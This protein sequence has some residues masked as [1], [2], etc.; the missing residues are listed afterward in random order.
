MDGKLKN[1]WVDTKIDWCNIAG[2]FGGFG[3]VWNLLSETTKQP[4]MEKSTEIEWKWIIHLKKQFYTGSDVLCW[5]ENNDF[6]DSSRWCLR[7][8]RKKKPTTWL[9]KSTQAE[10]IKSKST[11]GILVFNIPLT[12]IFVA[13][14]ELSL[15]ST[16]RQYTLDNVNS[17]VHSP[18]FPTNWWL[19]S[20]GFLWWGVYFSSNLIISFLFGLQP[21]LHSFQIYQNTPVRIVHCS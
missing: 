9:G 14:I 16:T 4:L 5:M 12:S 13:A 8:I 19:S 6:P 7:D 17:Q 1:S 3:I 11:S 15:E 2:V 21:K 10:L 18:Q 20:S